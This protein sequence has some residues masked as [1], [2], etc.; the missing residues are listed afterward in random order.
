MAGRGP[1]LPSISPKRVRGDLTPAITEG[2]GLATGGE[3]E[4][5][6]STSWV[7]GRVRRDKGGVHYPV[8]ANGLLV[9]D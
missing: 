7:D 9:G 5:S 8:T 1:I 4:G 6:A 3:G 2:E